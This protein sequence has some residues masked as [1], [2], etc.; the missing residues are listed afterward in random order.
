MDF[1]I[2]LFHSAAGGQ[3][4]SENQASD[5]HEEADL[6][7]DFEDILNIGPDKPGHE[8]KQPASQAGPMPATDRL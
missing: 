8:Q 2:P 6:R 7:P 1:L 4:A 3:H 5:P